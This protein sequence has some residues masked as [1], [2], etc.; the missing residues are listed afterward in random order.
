MASQITSQ[1]SR[2]GAGTTGFASAGRKNLVV[3][4]GA[5]GLSCVRYLRSHGEHVTVADSRAEPPELAQLAGTAPEV[6]V[7][8]PDLGTRLLDG[9]ERVILSPGIA[10][11]TPLVAAALAQGIPVVG[12]VELFARDIRETQPDARVVGITGTNGKS[13]V[14]ALVTAMAVEAGVHAKGGANLGPPVLDLLAAPR[15]AL[16]VLELSSYQLESTD[17]LRLDAAALLNVTP[18]H[19]DRYATLEDYAS[20]KARIFNRAELAV[21]G[22]NDTLCRAL[23]PDGMPTRTFGLQEDADYHVVSRDGRSWLCAP[24]RAMPVI[25]RDEVRLQGGHN[26]LN[27]LAALAIAG[28][29][30]LPW[31]SSAQALRTFG[32][33]PN[34]MQVVAVRHGVTYVNDS[35]G[36]NVGATLAAL[37]GL[38]GGVVLIAGGDGKGQDFTP[39]ANA[40]RGKVHNAVLIGRDRDRIA[41]VMDGICNVSFATDMNAAVARA[42]EVAQAGDTVLLSPA[43]A[44]LDMYSSY[45]AR[46]DAFI[47]AVREI[48][49]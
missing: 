48:S 19:M 4:L 13:T 29:V 32:G 49:Q 36:T 44:S 16:Y 18:D 6:R 17:T 3:G 14:T 20:A 5:T 11:R 40:C 21:V 15:P 28:A 25:A 39:L 7:H 22:A 43:C 1:T 2:A 41:T 38:S 34:R 24:E 30:G 35:K 26:T 31:D 12:D 45:V 33:L 47:V 9:M 10:R 23:V 27:S 8:Y 46:G 42:S 37:D